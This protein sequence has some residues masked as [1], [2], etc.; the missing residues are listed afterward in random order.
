MVT[1]NKLYIVQ[2]LSHRAWLKSLGPDTT[3]AV[4]QSRAHKGKCMDLSS[5][6]HQAW[7]VWPWQ[8]VEDQHQP[9]CWSKGILDGILRLAKTGCEQ[10]KATDLLAQARID[11]ACRDYSDRRLGTTREDVLTKSDVTNALEKYTE[12]S[13]ECEF[14]TSTK[15]RKGPQGGAPRRVKSKLAMPLTVSPN[16]SPELGRGLGNNYPDD[17]IRSPSALALSQVSDLTQ[18]GTDVLSTRTSNNQSPGQ[19]DTSF[20]L[21]AD[22]EHRIHDDFDNGTQT[23]EEESPESVDTHKR[24]AP[25]SDLL[26]AVAALSGRQWV[27]CRPEFSHTSPEQLMDTKD[28]E[29]LSPKTLQQLRSGNGPPHQQQPQSKS[30]KENVTVSREMRSNTPKVVLPRPPKSANTAC[31][32]T[33]AVSEPASSSSLPPLDLISNSQDMATMK[34][35]LDLLTDDLPSRARLD[36]ITDS[37]ANS[38]KEAVFQGE[39]AHESV[40]QIQAALETLGDKQ[41]VGSIALWTLLEAGC[42]SG[43]RLV[44][45]SYITIENPKEM[46]TKRRLR[47]RGERILLCPLNHYNRHWT[48][49]ILDTEAA[50]VDHYDPLSPGVYNRLEALEN[51]ITSLAEKEETSGFKDLSEWEFRGMPCPEQSNGYDC[52][53]YTVV[54]AYCRVLNLPIPVSLDLVLWRK[55]LSCSLDDDG[56]LSNQIDIEAQME[57]RDTKVPAN[58]QK[59]CRS[60]LYLQSPGPQGVD[61]FTDEMRDEE[62]FFAD[63]QELIRSQREQQFAA[64]RSASVAQ[65]TAAIVAALLSQSREMIS[66]AQADQD[67]L[68]TRLDAHRRILDDYSKLDFTIQSAIDGLNAAVSCLERDY[69]RF[70]GKVAK[71]KHFVARWERTKM[72]CDKEQARRREQEALKGAAMKDTAGKIRAFCIQ[73]ENIIRRFRALSAEL[74]DSDDITYD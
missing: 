61:I 55:A 42:P 19:L 72:F 53:V 1:S 37:G 40:N 13:A 25:D 73:K 8:L 65:E 60:R 32:S 15:K 47:L 44:D 34:E 20:Y 74:G 64:E 10:T 69:Q 39:E 57:D 62:S 18:H 58:S 4:D 26:G 11:R 68:Q 14:S 23:H 6:I 67:L 43:V 54:F 51:F 70:A 21:K 48:L 3:A 30:S 49:A 27:S 66:Q 29:S 52:G 33:P 5:K 59:A 12:S 35:P 17:T 56:K 46:L 7:G 71:H 31:A 45:C 41:W 38:D 63:T 28:T 36:G 50:I 2:H 9:H 22:F 24:M 16:R